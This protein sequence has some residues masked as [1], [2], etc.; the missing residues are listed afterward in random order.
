MTILS[1]EYT[2][3][4]MFNTWCRQIGVMTQKELLQ[5]VRDTLLLFFVLYA[6]TGNVYLAGSGI[7]L[8]LNKAA[9]VVHDDDKSLASRELVHRFRPPYFHLHGE[10][11]NPRQGIRLLDQGR[12]MILLDIPPRFQESLLKG[13]STGIQMQ[14][15]ATNS[16][17]G[18][19]AASYG[20]QIV[21]QFG[22]DAG[23]SRMGLSPESLSTVPNLR[24]EH[25][26]FFNPNLD[27]SW[28][29]TITELLNMI[30]LFAIMLP[31]AAM[32]REKEK[33][34][35]EQLLVSPLTPFQIMFSKVLAMMIVI[36]IGTMLSLFGVLQLIFHVPMRGSLA[37]FFVVTILYIFTTTGIGLFVAT[38]T[39]NLGQ[40][41]LLT[42]MIFAPMV[43]FSGAWTPPEALVGWMRVLMKFSPLHYFLD[44]GLGIL[45]KGA[46][47]KI[48]WKPIFGMILLGGGVFCFGLW[49]FR[50]QFDL[51]KASPEL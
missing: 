28:F 42:L 11:A 33:G 4:A 8:Q 3:F 36:L 32:A 22:L 45:L 16:V 6:F 14:V 10:V 41:G 21:G 5:L 35:I 34:T 2:K 44:V 50:R 9:T 13:E 51:H 46:G 40:V 12:E 26:I 37:L 23:F 15:D 39:R 43:F 24:E 1:T 25:R 30:T 29:M 7:S 31:A 19:L 17:L 27:N 38:I 18:T 20:E 48:L 47:L 49:R